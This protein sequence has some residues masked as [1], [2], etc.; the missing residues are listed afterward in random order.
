MI[1]RNRK[2]NKRRSFSQPTPHPVAHRNLCI[3]AV[4]VAIVWMSS[5]LWPAQTTASWPFVAEIQAS[6]WVAGVLAAAGLGI[7][8][9]VRRA[10]LCAVLAVLAVL[11]VPRVPAP[12]FSDAHNSTRVFS[13][14]TYWGK[15]DDK[16]IARAI[17]E[18][19]PD[20]VF[21]LETNEEEVDSVAEETGYLPLTKPRPGND[22]ADNVVGLVSAS[23]KEK[24]GAHGNMVRGL[25]RFQ[26]PRV[27]A[28]LHGNSEFVGVHAVAPVKEYRTAWERDLASLSDWANSRR[29][30]VL[31][32]DFNATRSHP[33]YRDF[34][35][36]DCT[37]HLA[38]TPTW[39]AV[40][41]VIRLDHIMTTGE[42][43]GG[44]TKR[45]LGTD[46]LAVWADVT[47]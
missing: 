12:N 3:A 24:T 22:R 8:N 16:R 1:P 34:E 4:V 26:T 39:P 19:K 20:V 5:I 29:H 45:I 47:T 23:Y 2:L 38:H 35:L 15:A 18:L 25:T 17:E 46:H 32:G 44:G 42:C 13:L 33:R 21:L 7:L 30:L 28:P 37:G 43:L 10:A 41:P 11:I 36:S 14:N 6:A 31:A 9:S 40:F 27:N